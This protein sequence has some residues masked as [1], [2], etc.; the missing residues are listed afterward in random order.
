MSKITALESLA[1]LMVGDGNP[2]NVYFVSTKEHGVILIA[3]DYVEA[4]SYWRQRAYPPET[5]I[6]LEDRTYGVIATTKPDPDSSV[7]F[8]TI[9]ESEE[10]LKTFRQTIP[11]Y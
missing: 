6:T 1:S 10:F 3:R 5:E 11:R 2:D 9:D 7:G 8:V 4:Y